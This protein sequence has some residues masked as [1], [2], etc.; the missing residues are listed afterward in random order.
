MYRLL[1][2]ILF[3]LIGFSQREMSTSILPYYIQAKTIMIDNKVY[4]EIA[5]RKSFGDKPCESLEQLQREFDSRL[6][7]EKIII[8]DTTIGKSTQHYHYYLNYRPYMRVD[9]DIY[10]EGKLYY[11][12]YET[13]IRQYNNIRNF[14]EQRTDY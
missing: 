3:P 10:T 1:I 13:Y 9:Y 4:V 7:A 6:L 12:D 5:P 11:M 2:L 8:Q 14:S